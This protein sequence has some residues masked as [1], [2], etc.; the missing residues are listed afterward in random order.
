MNKNDFIVLLSN[1]EDG[2]IYGNFLFKTDKNG[3]YIYN[4]IP[5]DRKICIFSGNSL[6]ELYRNMLE[7]DVYGNSFSEMREEIKDI[8]KKLVLYNSLNSKII[9]KN[10]VKQ[11]RNKL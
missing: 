8:V 5:N 9:N 11:I 1:I 10:E 3:F 4:F 6:V 2:F 7:K